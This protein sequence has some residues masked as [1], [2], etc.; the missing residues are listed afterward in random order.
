MVRRG[1]LL[2]FAVL[3]STKPE[4][5]S[6]CVDRLED[7]SCTLV[8]GTTSILLD[9]GAGGLEDIIYTLVE[10]T[11]SNTE[12]VHRYASTAVQNAQFEGSL[13]ENLVVF[14]DASPTTEATVDSQQ[15][16]VIAAVVSV[17]LTALFL[18]GLYRRGNADD[19]MGE[20]NKFKDRVSHLRAKRRKYFQEMEED[21]PSLPSGWMMTDSHKAPSPRDP[22]ITWSISDLTSD[23]ESIIST[24][25]L[26]RI[27]EEV[28]GEIS[29]G[30]GME[31]ESAVLSTPVSRANSCVHIE[32]LEFIADWAD[33][34]A[35]EVGSFDV[36]DQPQV[37]PSPFK[38]GDFDEI[39][40]AATFWREDADQPL[41]PDAD[42]SEEDDPLALP[43]RKGKGALDDKKRPMVEEGHNQSVVFEVSDDDDSSKEVLRRVAPSK[44][45]GSDPTLPLADISNNDDDDAPTIVSWAM[46]TLQKLKENVQKLADEASHAGSTE[47]V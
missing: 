24:L 34:S 22:P 4:D 43:V 23:A 17:L 33:I 27:D 32:H 7:S 19:D 29:D 14:G 31:G 21:A 2:L 8:R 35:E 5:S 41:A 28:S 47:R 26:D 45:Q 16:A 18:Y 42:D 30:E 44:Q 25:P 12:F 10:D 6:V 39:Y 15:I 13:G 3:F 36:E 20:A 38:E 1:A 40:D 37:G 11:L 46:G 9:N